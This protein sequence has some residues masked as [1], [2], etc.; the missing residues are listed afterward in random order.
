VPGRQIG[1]YKIHREKIRDLNPGFFIIL[2]F[3]GF[4]APDLA[5]KTVFNRRVR[6]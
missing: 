6:R 1:L 2:F 5:R 3:I 4:D